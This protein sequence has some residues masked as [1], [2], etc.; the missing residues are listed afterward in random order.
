MYRHHI[1][2]VSQQ[3]FL[4]FLML[5]NYEHIILVLPKKKVKQKIVTKGVSKS[6]YENME[7][8]KVIPFLADVATVES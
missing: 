4:F 3:F 7:C 8:I 2:G 5:N 1:E 6:I